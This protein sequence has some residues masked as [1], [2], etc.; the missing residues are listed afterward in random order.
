MS[1]ASAQKRR[2]RK[3]EREKLSREKY[4]IKFVNVKIENGQVVGLNER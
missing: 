2:K 1:I 4:R 3:G